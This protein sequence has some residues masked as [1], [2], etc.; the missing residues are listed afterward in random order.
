MHINYFQASRVCIE[1]KKQRKKKELKRE[2]EALI[3][4]FKLKADKTSFSQ[5]LS[6]F[7]SAIHGMQTRLL[8]TV[9]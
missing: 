5:N 9:E 3:K 7:F 2:R 8:A 4:K 6:Q 1:N